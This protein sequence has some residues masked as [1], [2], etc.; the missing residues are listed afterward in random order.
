[1]TSFDT[2]DMASGGIALILESSAEWEE[3]PNYAK[4]WV[5]KLGAKAISK[6]VISVDECLLEVEVDC[7]FFWLTYDDFQASIQLEPQSNAYNEIVLSIKKRLKEI[8]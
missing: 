1:M 4:K 2:V 5:D 6:P 8:T 7:G 3:F